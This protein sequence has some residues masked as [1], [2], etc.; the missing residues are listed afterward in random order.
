M[1]HFCVQTAHGVVP[2][3]QEARIYIHDLKQCVWAQLLEDSLAVLSLGLL[4]A[5]MGYSYYWEE[6]G[7]Q[8]YLAKNGKSVACKT[9]C[10]VLTV[11]LDTEAES[12]AAQVVG[13]SSSS[14][15][16]DEKPRKRRPAREKKRG[17]SSSSERESRKDK[18]RSKRESSSEDS[19][20]DSD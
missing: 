5:Q 12:H 2:R 7:G 13:D 15:S 11:T 19:S 4:C 17:K 20:S 8:A 10:N 14:E 18:K 1:C 9:V 16:E 6:G 3:H